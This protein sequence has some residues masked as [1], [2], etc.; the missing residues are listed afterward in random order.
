MRIDDFQFAGSEPVPV[1]RLLNVVDGTIPSTC[2]TAAPQ[3]GPAH[4][5]RG[6][7]YFLADGVSIGAALA[8]FEGEAVLVDTSGR[9]ADR[10][11]T[12][13]NWSWPAGIPALR[14]GH[15]DELVATGVL[16]PAR[17][18]GLSPAAARW[19]A[20]DSGVN[21]IAIDSVG[22]ESRVT[23]HYEVNATLCRAGVLI[24]EGL[25]NLA[26]LGPGR[27]WLEA[28]PLKVRGVEGTPCRAVVKECTTAGEHPSN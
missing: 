13:S 28:F 11:C 17:R 21:M 26:A 10:L 7:Y 6:A 20:H 3:P 8:R 16:D 15:M 24:L 19:P 25:V 5:S 4:R 18:P 12:T 22:V 1:T 9:D 14:S 27:L 23:G 2:A